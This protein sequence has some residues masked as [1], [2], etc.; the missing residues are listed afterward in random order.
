MGEAATSW[1]DVWASQGFMETTKVVRSGANAYPVSGNFH[2]EEPGS[3]QSLQSW[4]IY[5]CFA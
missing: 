3:I 1:T 4:S 2:W 5:R